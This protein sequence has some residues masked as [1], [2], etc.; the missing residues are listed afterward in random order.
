MVDLRLQ[1]SIVFGCHPF[2]DVSRV[3]L[4]SGDIPMKFKLVTLYLVGGGVSALHNLPPL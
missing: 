1:I 3:V 4:W 2:P